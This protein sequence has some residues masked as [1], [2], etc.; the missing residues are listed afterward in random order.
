MKVG[1]QFLAVSAAL[2]AA[3]A[4]GSAS[5][6]IVQNGSF[7]NPAISPTPFLV[8]PGQTTIDN[9]SVTSGSVDLID[10]YWQAHSGAQSIDLS[11]NEPGT[12][13]QT[14]SLDTGKLYLLTFWVSGNPDGPPDLK[15]F[16]FS[17]TNTTPMT[18]ANVNFTVVSPP[19]SRA[20][21]NWQERDWLFIANDGPHTLTFQ[22][23]TPGPYGPALDDV[24]VTLVPEPET[25]AM[26]LAGMGFIGFV[27]RR[28]R[29]YRSAGAA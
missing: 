7:E 13:T 5:A 12:L 6:Q 19:Q 23:T 3:C 17:V 25:Y 26:L 28:R 4:A 14:I 11:G 18:V 27:A 8:S 24:G 21:M 20:N 29:G 1:R 16:D 10:G 22:S 15:T 2:I 9:W